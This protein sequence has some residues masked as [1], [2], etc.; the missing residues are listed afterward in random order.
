MQTAEPLSAIEHFPNT[1]NLYCR[2]DGGFILRKKPLERIVSAYSNSGNAIAAARF[3][4]YVSLTGAK[5]YT[6]SLQDRLG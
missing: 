5:A 2:V 6:F 3:N 4:K 1:P